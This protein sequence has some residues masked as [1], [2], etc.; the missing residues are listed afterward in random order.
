[1]KIIF[2]TPGTGSFYCGVC[3]RDNALVRTLK[4]MGH[5]VTML[6]CYLPITTDEESI[7]ADMPI[8][9]GGIN[10]YLQQKFSLF[11]HTPHWVDEFFNSRPFLDM[12]ASQSGM[13]QGSELGEI[14]H[15]MLLGNEGNQ[16]KEVRKLIQWIE[17][18][19]VPDAICISTALQIGMAPAL[20][21]HLGCKV[22]S[23]LQGEDSFMDSLVE[24][25][26][27]RCWET[28]ELQCK[29]TDG[30]IAPS[31]Y[32][33]S[34]ME[35]RLHLKTGSIHITDNGIHI[36]D[37]PTPVET[38]KRTI[39]Y[40]ARMMPGKGLHLLIDAFIQLKKT[41]AMADVELCIAGVETPPD[42]EFVTQQKHKLETA[43]L[44]HQSHFHTNISRE[45]KLKLLSTMTVFS[46][47]A[48]Y[49]EP[50]GLY[51][52]EAMAAGIPVVQPKHSAFEEIV[53]STNGG[54]IY[55]PHDAE[56][57]ASQLIC[58]L[59]DLQ[60]RKHISKHSSTATRERYSEESM[61]KQLV[62]LLGAN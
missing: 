50:F 16:R 62:D 44:S 36:G 47:P 22:Y 28:F 9:F 55:E 52:I 32:F 34:V 46:V 29:Q 12:A 17:K 45:E 48:I 60:K 51:L 53:S 43:G 54:I 58:L 37:I 2:I 57:L 14:T 33:A 61:A 59:N 15:S 40:L 10:V 39:G 1:M 41:E 23:F 7:S 19:G 18:H 42:K 4:S 3:L 30:L 8:F 11:R 31:K 56:T 27:S 13:T 49:S 20:K 25:W 5:E 21:E 38:P 24:P 6:P 35:D 26:K